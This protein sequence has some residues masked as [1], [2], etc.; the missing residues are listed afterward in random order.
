MNPKAEEKPRKTRRS[1]KPKGATS[2]GATPKEKLS[3]A[4]LE[5]APV[6][7]VSRVGTDHW[8]FDTPS[9]S[10]GPKKG[11]NSRSNTPFIGW[12]S[13]GVRAS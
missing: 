11:R 9:V 6:I 4:D 10:S 12:G 3:Q 1:A 2:K 7:D 13:G 8:M 5:P